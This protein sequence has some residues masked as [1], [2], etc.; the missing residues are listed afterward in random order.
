MAAGNPVQVERAHDPISEEGAPFASRCR[1]RRSH[2]PQSDRL[3]SPG[4][5]G[6][7]W[8]ALAPRLA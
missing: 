8:T 7:E 6:L 3:L 1:R 5:P 4:N 2:R